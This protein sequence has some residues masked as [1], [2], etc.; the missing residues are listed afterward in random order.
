MPKD[1][2]ADDLAI[3]QH[4]RPYIRSIVAFVIYLR[5]QYMPNPIDEAYKI[6]DKFIAR[7]K[8]DVAEG[9]KAK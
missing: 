6:A 4:A 3:L 5:Y 1:N 2:P 9:A 8:E 7:L